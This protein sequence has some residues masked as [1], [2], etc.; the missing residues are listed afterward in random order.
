VVGRHAHLTAALTVALAANM[1][2]AFLIA[3]AM[4]GADLDTSDALLF[5]A[6]VGAAGL[7]F[8]GGHGTD[9]SGHRALPCGGRIGWGR[10]WVRPTSSAHWAT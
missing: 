6:S 4:A 9:R 2:M 10:A 1:L 8:A 7:A 3:A 5:G